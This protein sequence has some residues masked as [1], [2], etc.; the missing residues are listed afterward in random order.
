MGQMRGSLIANGGAFAATPSSFTANVVEGGQ[1]GFGPLLANLD[2]NTPQ[3]HLP[4]QF[5]VT[6][7]PTFF[8][9]IKD[10]PAIFKALFETHLQ[11]MDGLDFNYQMETEGTNAGRDGQQQLVP[12]R[13]TRTQITPSASWGSEKIGNVIYNMHRTWMNAMHDVDTQASSMSGF[14]A[15]GQALPPHVASMFAADI[16][17]IQYDTTMRPE[18]IIDAFCMT[19]FFPIDMGGHGYQYNSQEVHRPERTVN[20]SCIVQHNNNTVNVAKSLATLSNLHRVN[21][22]DALPVAQQIEDNLVGEGM[23]RQVNDYLSRFQNLDG[24]VG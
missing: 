20:Y 8:Q 4:L 13:Q 9:Y 22:Q 17:A 7:V 18:N 5:V 21:Y 1:L 10:G 16:F 2:A 3:V 23:A 19:N 11:S 14:I 6:H 12:T 15:P 24:A